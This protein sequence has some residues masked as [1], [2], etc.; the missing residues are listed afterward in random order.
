MNEF[1]DPELYDA[2]V[3]P[4]PGDVE[5]YVELAREAHTSG[6]P[7]LELASGT[8]RIAIPIAREGIDIVGLDA[9]P[10]MLGRAREKSEGLSNV[11]WVE[12][13]MRAFELPERFGLA[14][15]ALRSF[16]HL[17]TVD[18]QRSCLR[19]IHQHLADGGRLAINIFNPNILRIGQALRDGQGT[20]QRRGLS[21]THPRSGRTTERWESVAYD[22]ARQEF[23]VTFIDEE[24]GEG[25]VVASRVYRGL[26]L[27]YLF[28][29]EMEHLLTQAGF[30]VEALYG[31][32]ARSAFT[33]TSPE[34]VWL[35]RRPA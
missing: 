35:A 3:Q 27:R 32:F 11:R 33:D 14:F 29:F 22:H 23:D 17:L 16:Q 6:R 10:A 26:H 1:Y 12:G 30:E 34:M 20:L 5:F 25:G 8:G 9:S 24:L 4:P 31:D 13:D 28:R 15:I 2:R 7:V 21:F 19:C 18:D